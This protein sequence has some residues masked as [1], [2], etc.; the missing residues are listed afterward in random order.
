MP[1]KEL[2]CPQCGTMFTIDEADYASIVSQ[3]RTKE[4]DAELKRRVDEM[5][6]RV[7]AEMSAERARSAQEMERR[8]SEKSREVGVKSEEIVRLREQL[9]SVANIKEL[10]MREQI[11]D[12]DRRIVELQASLA[13][14]DDTVR[15]A[16]M[17]SES[18]VQELIQKKDIQIANLTNEV[19]NKLNEAQI[20]ENTLRE[21]HKAEM[22]IANEQIEFYRDLKSRMSTKMVGET[23]EEHCATTYEL[24][25]RSHMP[26]A[27]FGKDSEVV[28]HTKG[29]FIFRN[30]DDGIE[31]I[32]IM[33]EMKNEMD[34]TEK[35]HKNSEFFQKL[36]EDRRKKRCEYAVLVSTLEA[37]SELYN[38]GI[39]DVSHLY[40]KMYVVRPQFFV[41]IITLLD[42]ASRKSIEYKRKLVIAQNQS[43]DITNFER[44]L[45]DFKEGIQ[46]NVDLAHN[47]FEAA[48]KQID[49]SIASLTKT[50][51]QLMKSG[52]NL[53][54]AN[55]KAMDLTIRSL[56][57]MN[58]TMQQ[59]FKEERK[60]VNQV[61]DDE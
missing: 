31:Y 9:A 38:A 28:D 12:R 3:V 5:N 58:P 33:F 59:M 42:Q 52:N 8:L 27:Q 18:R 25:L 23:L 53:R 2:K 32:S 47:Q 46:R 19:Q 26:N 22:K 49:A 20:R 30:F 37:D 54:V 16:V 4:F 6:V 7:E 34:G 36:D 10:E 51:E 13:K 41:P 35:K 17:E 61:E 40:D 48:I 29:D 43:V 44:K 55:G 15:I 50:R 60:R 39:V 11:A 14:V 1:M 24:S 57:Y 56:T 21:Q 45:N